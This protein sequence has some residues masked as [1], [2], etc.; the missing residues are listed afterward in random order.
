[1]NSVTDPSVPPPLPVAPPPLPAPP[2]TPATRRL[3]LFL[4]I[5]G[6]GVLIA[7]LHLPL[8]LT[9]GVLRER[10]G[11]QEQATHE[12]AAV[13]G[14]RQLVMGPVLAVP[15]AYNTQVIR[16]K[17]VNGQAFNG[18]DNAGSF[19]Y[20]AVSPFGFNGAFYYAKMSLKF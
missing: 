10:Q 7:L 5:G 3:Y 15:Y 12:I 9:N 18:S 11:Y 14:Q 4:K 17:V 20:S 8:A 2:R 6:M 13:W 19:P 1:M 16:S